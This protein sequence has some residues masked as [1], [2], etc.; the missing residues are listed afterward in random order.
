MLTSAVTKPSPS[1]TKKWSWRIGKIPVTNLFVLKCDTLNPSAHVVHL[2]VSCRPL[3][4]LLPL[5]LSLFSI[6]AV[7]L[8]T[9]LLVHL[10][11][12]TIHFP[13]SLSPE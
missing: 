9:D 4:S 13:S 3:M 6:I 10:S 8:N 12:F 7:T 5:T 11:L 2:V 1:E